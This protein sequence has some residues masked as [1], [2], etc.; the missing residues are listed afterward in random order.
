M[1]K[2]LSM[3]VCL[4]TTMTLSAHAADKAKL[5]ERLT[6]ANDVLHELMAT[7]DKG[8][9]DSV[10]SKATCVIVVPGFKKG[11]FIVGAERGHG[12]ATCRTGHGWSAPAFIQ[13]TGASFGPQIGGQ[14]T[15]LVLVAMSHDAAEHLLHTKVK[16]GGD[17]G[18]AAGPVGREGQAST[19]GMANAGFLS[20]SRSKGAFIGVDLS[21]DVVNQNQADTDAYYG[22]SAPFESI[23]HGS[24]PAPASASPF[25][26]TVSQVFG[27]TGNTRAGE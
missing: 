7:P 15:D 3:A 8:I 9:P 1:L 4:A 24:V 20:Y 19:T 14:S 22:K 2:K 23:L 13:L 25:E 11:A 17:V 5:D 6:A 21:G 26:H 12:V 27:A 16:L 18:I 10:A